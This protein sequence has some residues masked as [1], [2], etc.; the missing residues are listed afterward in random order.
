MPRRRPAPDLADLAARLEALE[1]RVGRLERGK[2]APG[3]GRN[4]APPPGP[5]VKRC[6]G[7][8]L[9]LQRRKGRCAHCG[10]PL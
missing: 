5:K 10:L 9:P 4:A 1:E 2:P 7:C 8:G 3:D 6:P